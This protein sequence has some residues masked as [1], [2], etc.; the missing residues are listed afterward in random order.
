MWLSPLIVCLHV[1]CRRTRKCHL[2]HVAKQLKLLR[3]LG[4]ARDELNKTRTGSCLPSRVHSPHSKLGRAGAAGSSVLW[5]RPSK[6][7]QTGE[8]QHRNVQRKISGIRIAEYH[9]KMEHCPRD[10]VA[11][12][13]PVEAFPHERRAD[14]IQ[15]LNYMSKE[16]FIDQA[17]SV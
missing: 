5:H 13:R 1:E 6:S 17:T 8:H 3:I 7:T 12:S 14:V 9:R 2:G 10:E 4:L 16:T 11:D 15:T